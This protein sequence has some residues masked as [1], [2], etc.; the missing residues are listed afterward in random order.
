MHSV[1]FS[2]GGTKPVVSINPEWDPI[3]ETDSV[4]LS[5][6]VAPSTPE[7]QRYIWYRDGGWI[8]K[9]QKT[10]TLDR[11]QEKN[12]GKYQCQIPGSERSDPVRID[13]KERQHKH[14][15]PV[16]IGILIGAI[17]I[18]AAIIFKFGHKITSLLMSHHRSEQDQNVCRTP[19]RTV[20]GS[21][22]EDNLYSTELNDDLPGD[23]VGGRNPSL[24]PGD[25]T[26][27]NIKH[28]WRPTPASRPKPDKYSVAYAVVK[29]GPRGMEILEPSVQES[30]DSLI[31]E[32]YRG[33]YF[34]EN[35]LSD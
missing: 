2:G 14:L 35:P 6:N 19:G 9:E 3:L 22:T 32:N 31:Y 5:C 30:P 25:F 17:V 23:N 33:P 21:D 10:F 15:V 24:T 12:S 1:M 11:A 13:I 7:R 28:A 4:M 34:R 18:S 27:V 20:Q 26:Y 29:G 8:P 16:L